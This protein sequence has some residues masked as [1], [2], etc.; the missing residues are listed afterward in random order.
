VKEGKRKFRP[1]EPHLPSPHPEL[2]FINC[3]EPTNV[4][5][6]APYDATVAYILHFPK[7]KTILSVLIPFQSL[8]P[9]NYRSDRNEPA[10]NPFP[11]RA[12]LFLLIPKFASA[13]SN[14]ETGNLSSSAIQSG[15]PRSRRQW[16]PP[17][18]LTSAG[19]RS[20]TQCYASRC[21][22]AASPP[23]PWPRP[24]RSPRPRAASSPRRQT[25][26][27][28]PRRGSTTSRRPSTPSGPPP[29]RPLLRR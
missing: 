29:Y 10:S 6:P 13:D 11:S 28:R 16:R 24:P 9:D 21:R 18:S 17:P 5:R 27:P 22:A 23:P 15:G 1:R 4:A 14:Q 20:T 3:H 19:A 26:P 25:P 8:L 2:M 7:P 12:S